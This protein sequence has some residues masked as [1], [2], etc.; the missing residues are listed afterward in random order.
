MS[1]SREGACCVLTSSAKL[2]WIMRAFISYQ[3]Y[4]RHSMVELELIL[5][6]GGFIRY[7]KTVA[8]VANL[9]F[10]FQPPFTI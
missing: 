6:F 1:A 5:Q 2:T 10:S 9:P 7:L 3:Y 8:T 4:G